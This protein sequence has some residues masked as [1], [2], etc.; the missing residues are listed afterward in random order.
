MTAVLALITQ[1]IALIPTIMADAPTV[2]SLISGA[3]AAL[4]EIGTG[5]VE[6]TAD[7]QALDKVVSDLEAQWATATAPSIAPVPPPAA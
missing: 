5:G 2:I 3:R 7:F 4:N 6:T 1:V